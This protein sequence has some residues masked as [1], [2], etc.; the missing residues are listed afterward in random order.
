[1]KKYLVIVMLF[2]GICDTPSVYG[3]PSEA[4]NNRNSD[5]MAIQLVKF[6]KIKYGLNK[7]QEESALKCTKKYYKT[8]AALGNMQLEFAI[9]SKRLSEIDLMWKEELSKIMAKEKFQKLMY[10]AQKEISKVK[11]K[12]SPIKQSKSKG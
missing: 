9:R 11:E 10:D 3:Q 8:M 2:L 12:K 7:N 5:S 4:L 1:M 6:Y